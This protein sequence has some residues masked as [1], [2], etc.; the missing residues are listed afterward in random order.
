MLHNRAYGRLLC[1]CARQIN[2]K[3]PNN[4][5]NECGNVVLMDDLNVNVTNAKHLPIEVF[6]LSEVMHIVTSPCVKN[7]EHPS[8]IDLIVTN[9]PK[10]LYSPKC[11]DARLSDFQSM[12]FFSTNMNVAHNKPTIYIYVVYAF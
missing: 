6:Q 2:N 8:F 4:C 11:V 1:L 3:M 5:L 10:R 12:A 9:V 7:A